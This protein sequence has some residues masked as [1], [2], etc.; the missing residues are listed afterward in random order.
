MTIPVWLVLL[1]GGAVIGASFLLVS[2]V[3]DRQL[4]EG[5]HE[6]GWHA[7]AAPPT[8]V[9]RVGQAVGLLVLLALVAVG[10]VGPRTATVSLTILVVWVVWWAGYTMSVYLVG[11]TW[12]GINPFRLVADAIPIGPIRSY[13]DRLGAWPSVAGLFA[14]VWLEVTSR[15]ADDPRLMA[16]VIA[17]YALVT[18]T[19]AVVVGTDP[20][21]ANADPLSRVFRAYGRM[22]PIQRT[23]DG[24]GV[25]LPGWRLATDRFVEGWDDVGFVIALLWLTT[26]DGFVATPTWRALADALVG[27]GL[28]PIVAYLGL[29]VGGFGL[30]SAAYLLA[31][32]ASKRWART[33]IT[34][35]E[36]ALRF[37]QSLLPIAAGYHLAHYLGYFLSLGP[38]VAVMVT[39]PLAPPAQLPVLVLPAW[40]GT[41]QLAFV[42]VGHVIAIWVAHAI[43]FDTFTGRLQPIR[44]QYSFSLVMIAF[45]MTS[46]AIV[47][48]PTI[49]LPYL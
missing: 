49:Q 42:L 45:T 18:V 37:G 46:I 36:I 9:V 10:F 16:T 31:V 40:F 23:D 48:Q 47:Y 2:M 11:D 27:V 33:L 14:L 34:R 13:P 17:V 26:F 39:R 24:I 3:T 32:A 21:F 30:F 25:G 5:I 6:W 41:L 12:R 1:T 4:I 28:P 29:I 19:G 7:S 38:S 15:I 22:A 43:A 44:S 20:W 35:R 8:W